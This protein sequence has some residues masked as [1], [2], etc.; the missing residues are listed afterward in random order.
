MTNF[1]QI[2]LSFDGYIA[3]IELA[4]PAERNAMTP[5]MGREIQAAVDAINNQPDIRVAVIR[6]AGKSFCAGADLSTLGSEAGVGDGEGLGGSEN[7]YRAF[8]SIRDLAMPSI[9]AINGHAI[10][11]GLCFTLGADLRVMHER[12][13]A[14]MT[15][16]RLGIHPGMAAT[17]NLPR[18]VGPTIAADLLYTGRLFDGR[19][20]FAMGLVNRVAGDDFD[21]VVAELANAVAEAA[22]IAVRGIKQ[23]LRG[24]FDRTIDDALVREAA[25]QEKTFETEDAAEG[26]RAIREKRTPDFKAR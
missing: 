4:R 7:F 8:L 5:Q 9:A 22:P 19:E 3:T 20:A 13:K 16:S 14:G 25:V 2:N 18:L 6:G 1:E 26:I 24:T 17:W 10:G 15:F 21:E 12:A 11:A 23:T